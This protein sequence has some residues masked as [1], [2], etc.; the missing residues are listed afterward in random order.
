MDSEFTLVVSTL[1][2]GQ[3]DPATRRSILR[4]LRARG[5][6]PSIRDAIARDDEYPL[7]DARA[8]QTVVAW[9]AVVLEASLYVTIERELEVCVAIAESKS[10]WERVARM[11]LSKCWLRAPALQWSRSRSTLA[12]LT[13][14]R[15]LR[16]TAMRR[17]ARL[18]TMLRER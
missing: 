8:E 1:R 6:P 3:T 11:S 4:E 16:D 9:R 18:E 5:P 15:G 10:F 2:D 7:A 13:S 14:T 17:A 12:A